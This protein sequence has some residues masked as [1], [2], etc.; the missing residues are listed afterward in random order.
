MDEVAVDATLEQAANFSERLVDTYSTQVA[1]GE[2]G[3]GGSATASEEPILANRPP[4]ALLYGRIQSGKTAAMILTSALCL[5]NAFRVIIVLTA[6]NVALVQQTANRFKALSGPRVFSSV[7]DDG[8]YEWE[9]QEDELRQDI[10]NEGLVLVCAKDAFHLPPI[11]RFL[12]QIGAPS[13]P[14]LVFDDEADAATPDTTLAAR[15]SGRASAPPFPS[16]IHRRVVENPAPGQEGESIREVFPHSLFVQV[17]ATPFLLFLQRSTSALRPNV[18]FLLGPGDGYCGGQRFFGAFNPIAPPP[19]QPPLVLVPDNE[20]QALNRLR[21]P[22]GL[23]FSTEFF[24]VSAVAKARMERRWPR[25]GYKHLSHPSRLINQ[26][27]VVAGHLDSYLAEIR[28][29]LRNDLPQARLLFRR[30]YEELGRT[31]GDLPQLEALLPELLDA[32]RQA[33]VIRVNSETD[34]PQYGP[35]LNFLIGGN[36]LGRGLTIEDLLV[37]YYVREAQV[38]QMDTVW[39]HARMYGYRL[40]LMPYTRVY[41]PHRVAVLFKRIHDSEEELRE[42]LR[43]ESEG[44]DVPIRVA[45]GSRPT[46]PNA[47]EPGVLQVIRGGQQ[48]LHPHFIVDDQQAA[49][50]RILQ[51]LTRQAVPIGREE[52]RADRTTPIPLDDVFTLIEQVPVLEDD[53][54]SWNVGVI[55]ALVESFRD[56]YAGRCHV[57]V[58]RLKNENPPAEGWIRGRLGGPEIRFI[59]QAAPN[60]PSLA[61][62]YK[63]TPDNPTAWYPTLVLPPGTSTYIVNP[64]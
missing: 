64:M 29:V 19:P 55:S 20:G 39:Q 43:L 13:Y 2:V 5:D 58:R 47:T 63:G 59:R 22:P 54:G 57:Y 24:L 6:D 30:A 36:I 51:L 60:V 1:A 34:V 11:I 52:D 9:G 21:I 4:T 23:A 18:T 42:L 10:A 31:V 56:Q 62:L 27:G 25:E 26:H 44:E 28:R 49:A 37:T 41:L 33:E 16:T 50:G 8:S 48:Q 12:Q 15:T 53:P 46:R 17:T 45:R 3:A 61:L 32:I 14:A 35:R 40:P 38:S 7:K